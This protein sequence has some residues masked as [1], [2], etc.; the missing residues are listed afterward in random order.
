MPY[1]TS[2]WGLVWQYFN[3]EKL[4]R[5][6]HSVVL[7]GRYPILAFLPR[8]TRDR[9]HQ[10][11]RCTSWK[12]ILPGVLSHWGI[13]GIYTKGTVC[14][15]RK[16][17]NILKHIICAAGCFPQ[18]VVFLHYFADTAIFGSITC[19]IEKDYLLIPTYLEIYFNECNEMQWI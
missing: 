3:V 15:P 2:W 17:R 18:G 6:I 1:R 9:C 16:E 4:L 13:E 11:G 5:M 12:C 14:Y 19:L 7:F 8:S 10:E